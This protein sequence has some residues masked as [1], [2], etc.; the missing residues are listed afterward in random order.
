MDIST[1]PV[2]NQTISIGPTSGSMR[3]DALMKAIQEREQRI[4]FDKT[5]L[6]QLKVQLSQVRYLRND[7]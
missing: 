1:R 5:V 2:S 3:E 7:N 6:G 4:E